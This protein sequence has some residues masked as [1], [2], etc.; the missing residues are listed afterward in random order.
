MDCYIAKLSR[1]PDK[2]QGKREKY[3]G[4]DEFIYSPDK[5]EELFS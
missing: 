1:L 3:S 5:Q 4:K 2:E